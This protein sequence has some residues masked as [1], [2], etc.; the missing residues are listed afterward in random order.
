MAG[1]FA[2]RQGKGSARLPRGVRQERRSGY[3]FSRH[4]EA[5]LIPPAGAAFSA[6]I[7][8]LSPIGMCFRCDPRLMVSN[9]VTIKVTTPE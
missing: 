7:L 3:R 9:P 2:R 6:T 1:W 5:L 8:D 4:V